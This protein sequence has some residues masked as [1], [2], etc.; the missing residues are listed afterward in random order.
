MTEEAIIEE[1]AEAL[2]HP[3]IKQMIIQ[4]RA[5][6]S[7]GTYDTWSDAKVLD[8]MILTKAKR[9][10][11]PVIGDPDETVIARVKAYYNCLALLIEKNT[12][13][14]AVPVIN[15]THEGFG[16]AFI[17]VGKLIV[18]DRTLRD[19]HRFGFP[20]VEALINEAEKYVG[21]ATDLVETYRE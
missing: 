18:L 9:R 3:F 15:L 13:L 17:S 7:Y 14:M 5:V 20:S 11:I 1:G 8:P 16:R 10:E 4:L 21:K 12:G 6:D 2:E 19:V